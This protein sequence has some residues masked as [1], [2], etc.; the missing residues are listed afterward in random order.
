MGQSRLPTKYE[1]MFQNMLKNV[2]VKFDPVEEES[3]SGDDGIT[4][5]EEESKIGESKSDDELNFSGDSQM[6]AD[7]FSQEMSQSQDNGP[8]GNYSKNDFDED[9]TTIQK[10]KI[11]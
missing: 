10:E 7:L 4:E 2:R 1:V 5:P 6:S 3:K 11:F 8:S 9:L